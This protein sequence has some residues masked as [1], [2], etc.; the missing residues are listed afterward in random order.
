MPTIEELTDDL[1]IANA[2]IATQANELS[3]LRRAALLSQQ[4]F[5]LLQDERDQIRDNFLAHKETTQ[6]RLNELSKVENFSWEKYK[7]TMEEHA[8]LTEVVPKLK[9]EVESLS[10][11]VTELGNKLTEANQALQIEQTLSGS[12]KGIISSHETTIKSLRNYVEKARSTLGAL[13]AK[14]N[15]KELV[16][17][18]QAEVKILTQ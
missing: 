9:L 6:K 2:R 12:L 18:L 11:R 4:A 8:Q 7:R 16:P 1:N 15:Q 17:E 10:N 13:I 5:Q 14:I 3:E